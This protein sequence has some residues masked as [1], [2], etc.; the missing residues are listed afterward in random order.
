MKSDAA[1]GWPEGEMMLHAIGLQ[2][3]AERNGFRVHI[4][5]DASKAE[6]ALKEGVKPDIVWV[7][8]E[9]G[10][11]DGYEVLEK[12]RSLDDFDKLPALVLTS[13]FQTKNREQASN[14]AL[15]L[16]LAKPAN[17]LVLEAGCE[18]LLFADGRKMNESD[19]QE[20]A[21]SLELDDEDLIEAKVRAALTNSNRRRLTKSPF[22]DYK[23]YL[24]LDVL[25]ADSH[26]AR[27]AT[28]RR[29][30]KH[31]NK[32][33]KVVQSANE[34]LDSLENAS[35]DLVILS[36]PLLGSEVSQVTRL[37]H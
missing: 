22:V 25:L 12:L 17:H 14:D 32:A 36:H 24:P 19:H 30:L 20:E 23:T 27:G 15:S 26:R 3:T 8:A 33:T 9:L 2:A 34:V 11:D 1:L 21:P 37:I 13:A 18:A 7:A 5:N 31:F 6:A 29:V 10:D 4:A 28:T 35:F 16:L